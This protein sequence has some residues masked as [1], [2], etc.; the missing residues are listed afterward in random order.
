MKI[1]EMDLGISFKDCLKYLDSK[2]RHKL[3]DAVLN[4]NGWFKCATIAEKKGVTRAAISLQVK[5]TDRYDS[6]EVE[7]FLYAKEKNK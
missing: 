3:L 5:N 6:M 4:R 1:E 2:N 7:G